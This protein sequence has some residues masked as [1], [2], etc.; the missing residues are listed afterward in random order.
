MTHCGVI[1]CDLHPKTNCDK[2][3]SCDLKQKR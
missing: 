3:C 1:K 2:N